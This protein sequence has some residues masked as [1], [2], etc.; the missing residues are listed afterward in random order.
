MKKD[1][2]SGAL[3]RIEELLV[4]K[5]VQ[6]AY[7]P[8]QAVEMQPTMNYQLDQP[9]LMSSPPYPMVVAPTPLVDPIASLSKQDLIKALL[10]QLS[11]AD[12]E[13]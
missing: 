1:E 2:L 10:S 5:S 3:A 8:P 12:L 9:L 11:K 6:N 13:K 7:E 4:K